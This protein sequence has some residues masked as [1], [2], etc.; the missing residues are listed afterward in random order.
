LIILKKKLDFKFA[1]HNTIHLKFGGFF[2]SGYNKWL[3]LILFPLFGMISL[4]SHSASLAD[5]VTL[6]TPNTRISVPPG[7]SIS[8][9]IDVI[10]D[11]KELVNLGIVIAGMPRGWNYTLKWG[12]WDIGQIA[13]LPEK[14]QTLTLEVDVPLKVNKGTY[15]FRVI[16]GKDYSLPLTVQI[17]EQGT[18]DSEF[19]AKQGN[20]EGHSNQAYT[21][22]TVLKNRT[23]EKQLYSLR[24]DVPPGWIVTFKPNYIQATSVEIEPNATTDISVEINPPDNIEAGTYRIPVNASNNSTLASVTLEIVIKGTYSMELTTPT[25][26][27][28]T[29]ITAGNEKDVTLLIKNTGSIELTNIT[30]N[31]VSPLNWNINFEPD[32]VEK[33]EPGKNVKILA[34]IK[35]DKKAIAGDYAVTIEAKTTET[36]SKSSFRVSVKTPLLLGW[37]GIMIILAAIGSIFYLFKKFGRR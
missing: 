16:A 28:S 3:S 21:F 29:S 17:T 25:G 35:A 26:L 10:N 15:R 33:L 27:L 23:A 6:Y 9:S 37:I 24:A 1:F 20:M 32:T 2:M 11:S 18:F 22:N 12:S 19:T 31:D 4:S 7:E 13:I 36:S 5:S 30:M 14:K 8:Y 34:T